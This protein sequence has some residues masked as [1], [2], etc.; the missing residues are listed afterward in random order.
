MYLNDIFT[1]QAN[2]CGIPAISITLGENAEKLPFG[3]QIMAGA[4]QESKL[5]AF[6]KQ[7]EISTLA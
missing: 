1:V 7:N 5:L 2:V 3:L 6:A 4:F